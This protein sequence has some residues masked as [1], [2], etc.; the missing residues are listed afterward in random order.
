MTMTSARVEQKTPTGHHVDLAVQVDVRGK[1]MATN[2]GKGYRQGSVR[3]RTQVQNPANGNWTKRDTDTGRFIEQKQ[4]GEPF[5]GV[6][7][8]IDDRRK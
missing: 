7:K 1:I 2:T 5:K 4:D 3:D 8:E 6:A